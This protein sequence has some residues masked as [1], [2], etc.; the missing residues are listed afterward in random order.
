MGVIMS[1]VVNT[2]AH[3]R[4]GVTE[5]ITLSVIVTDIKGVM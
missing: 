5:F 3:S 2:P 1:Y 4:A